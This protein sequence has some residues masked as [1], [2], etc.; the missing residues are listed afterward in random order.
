VR[1]SPVVAKYLGAQDTFRLTFIRKVE[2]FAI[3]GGEAF[4][5]VALIPPVGK[6]TWRRRIDRNVLRQVIL[7]K[8][9]EAVWILK[10]KR[11]KQNR[12]DHTEDGCVRPDAQRER[13]HGDGGEAGVL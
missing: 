8:P 6:I 10:G 3:P 4:K 11:P 5:D 7:P 13:E 12:V 9:H 1:I 2:A